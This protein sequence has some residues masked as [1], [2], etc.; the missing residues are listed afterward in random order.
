MCLA[1]MFAI[2]AG[3]SAQSGSMAKDQIDSRD[4]KDG[5]VTVSG[6]VTAAMDAGKYMLSNA[7]MMSHGTM[8]K[9]KMGKEMDKHKMMK[10][11]MAGGHTMSYELVGGSGLK[12][13]VGHQVEV[14]GSL[15]RSDMDRMSKMDKMEKEKMMADKDVKAMKLNVKSVKMTSATCS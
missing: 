4:M 10:P 13:H 2:G 14:M 8:S 6:C 9:D 12:E 15:S 5:Q 3:V 7:K 11:T 1:T